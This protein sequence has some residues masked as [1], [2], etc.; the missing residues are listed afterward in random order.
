MKIRGVNRIVKLNPK[1]NQW[2][3]QQLFG[4]LVKNLDRLPD[5][6]EVRRNPLKSAPTD[7]TEMVF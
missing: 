6:N 1:S 5:A 3:I 2:K 4:E 7:L